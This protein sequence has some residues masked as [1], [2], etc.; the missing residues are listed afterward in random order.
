MKQWRLELAKQV[1]FCLAVIVF[2]SFS[3]GSRAAEMPAPKAEEPAGQTGAQK[4]NKALSIEDAVFI[5]LQNHPSI[6]AA[7]EQVGVQGAVLGQQLGA[8]YP[9]VSLANSYRTANSTGGGDTVRSRESDRFLS[10]AQI[11]MTL[12]NFGKR[13]GA[14]QSA[15]ETL[16]AT[17]YAY[18]T[19]ANNVVLA[20]KQAYYIYLQA[21]ALLK[22]REQA[23]KDQE[24]LVRQARGFFEVGTKAKIDVARAESNFYSAQADLITAQNNLK[25]ALVTLRN[26]L[27]VQDLPGEPI[28]LA[29]EPSA[30]PAPIS[31]DEAR[32]TAFSARPEL[33]QF[34][35]QKRSQD[36]QIAAARRGHLPDVLFSANYGRT[37]SSPSTFGSGVE[38]NTFPLQ[39]TWQVQL[40][41]NIPIFDG[42]QTTNKVEQALRS[43]YVVKNQEEQQK[44]QVALEVEQSY[45]NLVN[46]QGRIKATEAAEN[47]AKEN[48]DLAN[49]RY[50]V[51]VG[52]IIEIT[53]AETLYTSAQTNHINA[54]YDYKIAEAQLTKAMGN[55]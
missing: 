20:A 33:L 55:Q 27:G 52:S 51:G 44:Q 34:E 8:Y 10:Q 12:Y 2:F 28:L 50:Q 9:T 29:G 23:V 41:L 11:A 15:R 38:V 14:V 39:P 3:P 30:A 47:A 42:F 17:R 31:L 5:A 25:I 49:G 43:Y 16:D 24:L 7:E 19:T 13:E 26:A 46:A 32:K 36:Q 45:L 6:K 22:V 53:D 4:E 35:A 18:I 54:L 40:S 1:I 37:G 48:F 21:A